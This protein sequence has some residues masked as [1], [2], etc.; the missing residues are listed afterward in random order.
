MCPWVL[1][2]WGL[3]ATCSHNIEASRGKDQPPSAHPHQLP[4]SY[5]PL[6]CILLTKHH[7]ARN[8]K[9]LRFWKSKRQS[10]L[11]S[12]LPKPPIRGHI[13]RSLL[14]IGMSRIWRWEG[15]GLR[16]SPP[17]KAKLVFRSNPEPQSPTSYH[18]GC[19]T[20]ALWGD[21]GPWTTHWTDPA[22]QVLP[23]PSST[24]WRDRGSLKDPGDWGQAGQEN[25][26]AFPPEAGKK[27]GQGSWR[28]QT[29]LPHCL[30][31]MVPSYRILVTFPERTRQLHRPNAIEIW[32]PNGSNDFS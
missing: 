5:F 32:A 6:V 24:F 16:E 10:R 9:S 15:A 29:C 13:L 11:C 7:S 1:S 2:F 22:K 26:R 28:G 12:P 21:S 23:H 30:R 3:G 4:S 20:S 27:Q 18:P 8:Q 17:S 31:L 19:S 14:D 25:T